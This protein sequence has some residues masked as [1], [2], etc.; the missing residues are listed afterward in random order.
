MNV[1]GRSSR[2]GGGWITPTKSEDDAVS[3]VDGYGLKAI[4]KGRALRTLPLSFDDRNGQS[5]IS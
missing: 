4:K 5:F 2:K 1:S 3:N